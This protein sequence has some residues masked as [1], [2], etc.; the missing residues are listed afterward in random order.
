M[1]SA[2]TLKETI[3]IRI[4]P[5]KKEAL[6]R[7]YKKR[8]TTISQATRKFFDDELKNTL[9]PLE[10]FDAIMKS[11]E[12]KRAAYN[13]PEPTVDDIVKYVEKVR[14]ERVNDA[15][16]CVNTKTRSKETPHSSKRK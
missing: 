7:L 3:R 10:R 13:A 16:A 12:K 6:N 5:E 2:E 1:A 14:E 8:G 11:A 4:E 9:D 15:F